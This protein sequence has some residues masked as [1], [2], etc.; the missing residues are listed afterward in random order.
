MPL[1]IVRNDITKMEADALVNP[2]NEQL[3][4]SG[5]VDEKIH[6]AA[7]AELLTACRALGGCAVGEAKATPAFALNAKYVI[8]TVGPRWSGGNK[9]EREQL[10]SCYRNCLSLA[11]SLGCES[12]AIPLISS[13]DHGYPKDRVLAEAV[14]V[15][16]SFLLEYDMT[17]SIVVY[18]DASYEFS[19]ML[20]GEI[21]SYIDDASQGV[22]RDLVL[23]RSLRTKRVGAPISISDNLGVGRPHAVYPSGE[24]KPKKSLEQMLSDIE[25]G[26]SGTVMRLI[27]ERGMKGYECY[28]LANVDKKI[29]SKM[30][31]N[32]DYRPSKITAICFALALRLDLEQT[33]SLLRTAGYSLSRSNKFDIIIEYYI[34]HG[35]YNVM[36]IN[37]T[38]FEFDLPLLG[39]Q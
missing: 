6:S 29:F 39:S 36:D 16:S 35:K 32:A 3:L 11:H 37:Q 1:Y 27:K 26:F 22:A 20:F 28:R 30:K 8:H 10:A 19:E 5:G 17:V 13:G 4:P 2:S 9:G 33:N 23:Q 15:V 7:G 34:I 14:S 21:K 31:N 24:K 38:L 12:V 18:D 25:L